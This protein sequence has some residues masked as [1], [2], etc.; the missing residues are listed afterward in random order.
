MRTPGPLLMVCTT[1]KR[2]V[3]MLGAVLESVFSGLEVCRY[4][5]DDSAD[6][7]NARA[8]ALGNAC[9]CNTKYYNI[10]RPCCIVN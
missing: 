6:I 1:G 8:E 5:A 9:G 2:A 7:G 3:L 4:N 10:R